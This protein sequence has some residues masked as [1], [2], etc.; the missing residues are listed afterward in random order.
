MEAREP[1]GIIGLGAMGGRMAKRLIAAG[2]ACLGFDPAASARAAFV[3]AGGAALESVAAVAARARV[4]LVVVIDD[5]QVRAVCLGEGGIFASA[6]PGTVSVV[7]S[8]VTPEVCAELARAAS[9]RGQHLVDAPMIRGEAAAAAGKLLLMVGGE[10]SVVDRL[11]PALAPIAS[12]VAHLGEVGAGQVGKMVNNM[13]LWATVL[14]NQEGVAFAKRMG[15]DPNVLREALYISSGDNWSLHT[16]ETIVAQPKWWHQ[17]DLA[18]MLGSAAENGIAL[19]FSAELKRQMAE[20]SLE[21][22]RRLFS[23][24]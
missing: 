19:P 13:L 8:S 24:G 20:M 11:R 12:D 1:I 17:K 7:M 23:G 9:E 14:A 22:A 4:I 21:D 10:K 2:H 5:D 16:W 6:A 18:V 3:E 15:V